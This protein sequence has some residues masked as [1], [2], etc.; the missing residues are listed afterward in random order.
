MDNVIDEAKL[1]LE[2]A[3][4]L[5]KEYA[6]DSISYDKV[7][8]HSLRVMNIALKVAK[9]VDGIDLDLIKSGCILHDIGRLQF[10][11]RTK[12]GI[13]H[14]VEGEKILLKY[15]LKKHASIAARHIGVGIRPE[16]IKS[17]GLPLPIRDYTPK[18]R[19]EMIICYADN[20]DHKGLE[21]NEEYVIERF[22][23]ELGEEYRK[24]VIE[25]HKEI[26]KLMSKN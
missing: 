21:R 20:L 19:E 26:H 17:Q 3:K 9:C 15:G 11:P 8:G 13:L 24:R 25:F 4:L 18:T 6:P 12:D 1:D 23:S 14:G 10:P 22:V 2:Q 16:D 5:L 7:L